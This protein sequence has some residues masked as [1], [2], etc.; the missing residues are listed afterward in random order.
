MNVY[1][2]HSADSIAVYADLEVRASQAVWQAQTAFDALGFSAPLRFKV[3][4]NERLTN[5]NI[6]WQEAV[7]AH[8]TAKRH[9]AAAPHQETGAP[10]RPCATCGMV[11]VPATRD[12]CRSCAAI[13]ARLER[14]ADDS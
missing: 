4:A 5:A 11:R 13:L 12:M 9:A 2:E 8:D 1:Q 10:M 7:R 14:A 6:A 3:R